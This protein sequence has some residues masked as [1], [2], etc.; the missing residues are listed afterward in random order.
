MSTARAAR[1]V[2]AVVKHVKHLPLATLCGTVIWIG[3]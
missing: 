3:Q 1:N 2:P